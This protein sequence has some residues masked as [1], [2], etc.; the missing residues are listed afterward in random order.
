MWASMSTAW[1]TGAANYNLTYHAGPRATE[2]NVPVGIA[3]R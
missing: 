2:A 1:S 3:N